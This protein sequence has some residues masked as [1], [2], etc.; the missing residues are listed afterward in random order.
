MISISQEVLSQT[1]DTLRTY[2]LSKTTE[3]N[4]RISYQ[5]GH[6]VITEEVIYPAKYE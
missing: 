6:M 2:Y 1:L 5:K 4:C 3:H